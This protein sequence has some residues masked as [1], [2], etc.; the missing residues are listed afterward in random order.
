[1]EK[2]C[3]QID[4]EV[5]PN[6]GWQISCSGHSDTDPSPVHSKVF[7]QIIFMSSVSLRHTFKQSIQPLMMHINV[8]AASIM[9]WLK[10]KT[11][12]LKGQI[13]LNAANQL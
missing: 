11:Q 3:L 6:T 12:I 5:A 10:K 1:M 7:S 2:S 8:L 13:H 9:K 4:H